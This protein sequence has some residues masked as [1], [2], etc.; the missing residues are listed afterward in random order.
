MPIWSNCRKL[1]D[2]KKIV[3]SIIVIIGLLCSVRCDDPYMDEKLAAYDELPIGLWL[4]SQPEYS[5]WVKL[6]KKAGLFDALNIGATFTCFVANDNAVN[7][8]LKANNWS[9][10]EEV[11]S[12]KAALLVRYHTIAGTSYNSY[13]F[14]GKLGYATLS[15]DY[16]SAEAKE[17]GFQAIFVNNDARIVERDLKQINGMVHRLDKVLS[18]VMETVWDVV[19]Q[20]RYSIFRDAVKECGLMEILARYEKTIGEARIR[21]YKTV[22]VVPDSV[23]NESG[24]YSLQNLKEIYPDTTDLYNYVAYH[25]SSINA[26]FSELATF[27]KESEMKVK[28]LSTYAPN[29]LITV[30]E[31][32]K[33][34][35]FNRKPGIAGVMP[36]HLIPGKYNLLANNGYVHEVDNLL[37]VAIAESAVTNWE[38]SNYDVFR[39][40]PDFRKCHSAIDGSRPTIDRAGAEASGIRWKT[41]PDDD[42][43]VSYYL[44]AF[45]TFEYDDAVTMSLGNVGWAEFDTPVI[46]KGKYSVTIKYQGYNKR[47]KGRFYFDGKL[48]CD[49]DFGITQYTKELGTIEFPEQTTHTFRIAVVRNGEMDIDQFIFKPVK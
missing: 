42:A 1:E 36:V 27:S 25:V 13:S 49:L 46:A 17:G 16:L 39:I 14:A 44:R 32:D 2:M 35:V 22:F 3:I 12:V 28:N 37:A 9:S 5:Q 4:A 31:D 41:I 26:D 33:T 11:D 8:Y 48:F 15:G 45:Q 43:A 47:G 21:D 40:L 10:V 19:N 6:L 30:A 38:L 23:F 24:I 34:L 20:D 7:A 29:Q 18:M